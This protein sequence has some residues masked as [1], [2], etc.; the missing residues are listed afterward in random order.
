MAVPCGVEASQWLAS[1]HPTFPQSSQLLRLLPEACESPNS[2]SDNV[3]SVATQ[4][5]TF[6]N[7]ADYLLITWPS[8]KAIATAVD[9]PAEEVAQ[10]FRPNFIV[11]TAGGVP[12]DEDNFSKLFI[13]GIPFEVTGKCTRCQMISI[14][15][16]TGEKNPKVLLAL[17]DARCGDKVGVFLKRDIEK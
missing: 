13:G 5:S 6:T 4:N 12:F 11:D 15:Q 3:D 16:E 9:L 2:S 14:D 7:E 8:I 1:I 10:R 17:R